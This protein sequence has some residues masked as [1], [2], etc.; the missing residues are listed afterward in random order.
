V[1]R[2]QNSESTPA[3]PPNGASERR[4]T[5]GKFRAKLPFF[6]M[7]LWVLVYATS[8]LFLI[9]LILLHGFRVQTRITGGALIA[10]LALIVATYV[11]QWRD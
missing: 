1:N 6:R 5:S 9:S 11:L 8:A 2:E 7:M 4:K 10:C 3:E